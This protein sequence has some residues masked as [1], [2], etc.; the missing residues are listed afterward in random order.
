MPPTKDIVDRLRETCT[1]ITGPDGVGTGYL[2]APRR[3]A[4]AL[5]VVKSWRY[6]EQYPVTSASKVLLCAL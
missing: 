1:Q 5:H 2:I 4:T 3:L 6:G